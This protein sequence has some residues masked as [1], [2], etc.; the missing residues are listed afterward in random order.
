MRMSCPQ[1]FEKL[2]ANRVGNKQDGGVP[3]L[4]DYA[5]LIDTDTFDQILEMDDEDEDDRDFSKEI[6]YGFFEQA[7]GTFEKMDTAL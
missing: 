7:E 4:H 6:V 5:E 2:R 3:D 1:P